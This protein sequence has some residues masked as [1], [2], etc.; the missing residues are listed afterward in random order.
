LSVAAQG[1][2]YADAASAGDIV[3]AACKVVQHAAAKWWLDSGH[4]AYDVAPHT[5]LDW[6]PCMCA[7]RLV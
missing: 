2:K 7:S 1:L 4:M 6:S 3:Q 5:A